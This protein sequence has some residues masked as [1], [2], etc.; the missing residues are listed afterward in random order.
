MLIVTVEEGKAIVSAARE[1]RPR[2]SGW[3]LPPRTIALSGGKEEGCSRWLQTWQ[4]LLTRAAKAAG[5]LTVGVFVNAGVEE[6]NETA[7][8]VGLDL[9]QLHGSEGWEVAEKLNRPCVRVVHMLA[10]STAEEVRSGREG[11]GRGGTGRKGARNTGGVDGGEAKLGSVH[12]RAQ[13]E[14]MS[15]WGWSFWRERSELLEVG[16]GSEI[17][18]VV[19]CL[20]QRISNRS[21]ARAGGE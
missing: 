10:E 2:P 1:R 14:G 15:A 5:P 16:L 8:R 19:V 21:A 3:A 18:V 17:L 12:V 7:D 20:G 4:G 11:G 6:M 13:R 9:I